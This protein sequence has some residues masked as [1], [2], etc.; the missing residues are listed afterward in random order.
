MVA[1]EEEEEGW[2][3]MNPQVFLAHVADD[4]EWEDEQD[5]ESVKTGES[6]FSLRVSVSVCWS[7]R[8]R[9]RAN[10]FWLVIA[11]CGSWK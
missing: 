6:H 2:R 3:D 11:Q 9:L 5:S 7:L 4:E 10:W 8:E 1:E